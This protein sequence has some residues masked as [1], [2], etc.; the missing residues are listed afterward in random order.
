[1]FFIN[2]FSINIFFIV[3]ENK[4]WYFYNDYKKIIITNIYIYI[5]IYIYWNINGWFLILI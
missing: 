5:Y 3:N 2:I 4:H 1:M